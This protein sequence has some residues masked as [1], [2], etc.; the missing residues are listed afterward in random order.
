MVQLQPDT[1]RPI[2]NRLK[3]AQGQLN[4]VIGPTSEPNPHLRR[5]VH[6]RCLSR[7]SLTC[8]GAAGTPLTRFS[9]VT[10]SGL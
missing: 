9:T 8:K 5:L 2:S 6:G 10:P 3:R 7:G 4:A 1:V